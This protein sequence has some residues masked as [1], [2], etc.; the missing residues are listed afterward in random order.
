MLVKKII[1]PPEG[2]STTATNPLV[3][4]VLPLKREETGQ[5]G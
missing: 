3:S 1:H 5:I 4:S 2:N